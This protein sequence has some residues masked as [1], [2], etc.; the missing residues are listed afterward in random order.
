MSNC[1]NLIE[2]PVDDAPFIFTW[3][4]HLCSHLCFSMCEVEKGR[5]LHVTAAT[6]TDKTTDPN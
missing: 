4:Y 2:L 5:Q 3:F 6:C 1:K